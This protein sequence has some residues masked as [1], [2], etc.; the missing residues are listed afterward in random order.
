MPII[1]VLCVHM[2]ACVCFEIC[3]T[4]TVWEFVT[5]DLGAQG[6]F[7]SVIPVVLGN[8]EP[9]ASLQIYSLR[10]WWFADDLSECYIYQLVWLTTAAVLAGGRY[11]KLAEQMGSKVTIPVSWA[12]RS[13]RL[14]WFTRHVPKS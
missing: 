10:V 11:D 2:H 9:Y 3:S 1:F 7:W 8:L 12:Y 13:V 14:R 6:K 4:G 5:P